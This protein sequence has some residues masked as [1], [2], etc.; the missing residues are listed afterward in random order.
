MGQ[1]FGSVPAAAYQTNHLWTGLELS[2]NWEGKPLWDAIHSCH[3]YPSVF[4]ISDKSEIETIELEVKTLVVLLF[5][6]Y[7]FIQSFPFLSLTS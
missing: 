7:H 6:L 4:S 3:F 2:M 5:S 1:D